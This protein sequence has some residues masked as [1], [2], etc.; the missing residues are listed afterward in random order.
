MHKVRIT[1]MSAGLLTGVLGC[2]GEQGITTALQSA[3]VTLGPGVASPFNAIIAVGDTLT[4]TLHAKTI[5]GTPVTSFDSVVYFTLFAGDTQY[6]NV[7]RTG[8][9]TGLRP[10]NPSNPIGIWMIGFKGNAVTSD[11]AFVQV[12]QTVLSGAQ[13]S[14][15]PVPPDS[16]QWPVG[17][18][19][20]LSP[21]VWDPVSGNTVS[22][23]ALR[24]EF[25]PGDSSSVTCFS[26]G[27][28]DIPANVAPNVVMKNGCMFRPASD[29]NGFNAFYGLKP[30]TIW[31]YANV[32]AYGVPLRDSLRFVITN[33][34]TNYVTFLPSMLAAAGGAYPLDVAL[35][36]GG[37]VT[38]NNSF[39][40]SFATSI[41]VT[42]DHPEAA[43]ASPDN[44]DGP[45]GNV[46]GLTSYMSDSRQF[47][48]AGT[49]GYTY[50]ITDGTAPFKGVT[51]R[52]TITVQ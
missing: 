31:I 13:L 18:F 34:S 51:G 23:V 19:K 22:G 45:S 21:L 11:I 32:R 52:G 17:L 41:D 25:G 28:N 2:V 12:T 43:T 6:V 16:A 8:L 50:T 20:E 26:E 7:S 35:V 48:T 5:T 3:A 38:F 9:V 40:P 37:V 29:F 44:P 33:P 27:I 10:T 4:V 42:F 30:D 14:I 1:L 47:L 24:L 39:D 15:Q 46:H 36:P 49:Y